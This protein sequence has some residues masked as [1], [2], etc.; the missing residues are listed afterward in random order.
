MKQ[1]ISIFLFAFVPFLAIAQGSCTSGECGDGFGTYRFANGDV[2]IGQFSNSKQ[3]GQGT[4]LWA[5]GEKYEGAWD[6]GAQTGYA[7][8][9]WSDGQMQTGIFNKGQF[10]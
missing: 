6:M 9:T 1:L 3:H 5:T 4:F 8:F 10:V 7:T 2:Y